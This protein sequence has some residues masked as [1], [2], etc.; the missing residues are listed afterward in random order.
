MSRMIPD[1]V[2]ADLRR[3]GAELADART[4]AEIREALRAIAQVAKAVPVEAEEI[5]A[6]YTADDLVLV[7]S[8]AGDGGWSLHAPGSTDE[9]IASG[10]APY[11]ASGDAEMEDGEWSRP[12]EQDYRAA[13]TALA[14]RGA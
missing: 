10:D 1:S 4:D 13:L 9:A 6:E 3:L 11:L 7:R 2:A 12:D 14:G 5:E 8:D